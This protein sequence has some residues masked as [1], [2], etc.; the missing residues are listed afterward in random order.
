MVEL[1]FS[2][3]YP[4]QD[5]EFLLRPGQFTL[6]DTAEKERLIQSGRRHYSEMLSEETAPDAM[7][8]QL[9][10]QALQ[11]GGQR[12][13]HDIQALALAL[14]QQFPEQPLLLLSLV[15]AGVPI[16]ILLHRALQALGGQSQHYGLSIIRDK[17]LDTAALAH[18]R[19]QHPNA[20]PIFIDGWTGKGAISTELHRSLNRQSDFEFPVYLVTLA[21]AGGKAWLAASNDDWLIPSSMLGATVSGLVS[22]SVLSQDGGWHWCLD[23]QHL[24]AQ[25]QSRAFIEHIDGL[26][27]RLP[28]TVTPALWSDAEREAQAD[29]ASHSLAQIQREYRVEHRNHLKPGIAEATRALLRRVPDCVLLRDR[30]DP[31]LALLRHLA[32]RLQVRI[33]ILGTALGPYR[34]MTL[35]RKVI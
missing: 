6:T 1:R 20:I 32:E 22:R 15:R 25:D 26:R 9:F 5:I 21:D 35:I 4:L 13:A 28:A 29:W 7:Q 33:E 27:Q 31:D 34:A 10:T 16:G 14:R 23:C 12:M 19:Q 2:G 17:G 18:A 30:D 24:Q 8:R 3:S 11:Q